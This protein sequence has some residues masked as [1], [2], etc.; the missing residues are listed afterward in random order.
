M[1]FTGLLSCKRG[2]DIVVASLFQAG[3]LLICLPQTDPY[4][5]RTRQ[6]TDSRLE[7]ICALILI[8]GCRQT[9]NVIFSLS[10][11]GKFVITGLL[12]G[13]GWK[14]A[15][16]VSH[17]RGVSC[18]N[19][20]VVRWLFRSRAPKVVLAI[21]R[22]FLACHRLPPDTHSFWICGNL[23]K[24]YTLKPQLWERPSPKWND[25]QTTTRGLCI[26]SEKACCCSSLVEAGKQRRC[27]HSSYPK[28]TWKTEMAHDIPCC[29]AWPLPVAICT[30][31]G[32]AWLWRTRT[33]GKPLV[34]R[35]LVPVRSTA[36]LAK[37]WNL[38]TVS[39]TNSYTM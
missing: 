21:W 14:L 17:G 34:L 11:V 13:N 23:Y 22:L 38:F 4:H 37:A 35:L 24:P 6:Y 3:L 8:W 27:A 15:C 39:H 7:E 30:L 36:T 33:S 25:K 31:L 5:E 1:P 2:L 16:T 29:K 10:T 32:S 26:H 12:G 19:S 20:Q 28:C 9:L 18:L